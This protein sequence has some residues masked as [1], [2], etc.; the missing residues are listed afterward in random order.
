VPIQQRVDGA[1]LRLG[2]PRNELRE[3]EA[4][5]CARVDVV[6]TVASG[7]PPLSQ[8]RRRLRSSTA[9]DLRQGGL[10]GC[11]GDSPNMA[12][13]GGVNRRVE[14]DR[15][16]GV[17]HKKIRCCGGWGEG[18]RGCGVGWGGGG[19]LGW[20]RGAG[21]GGWGGNPQP[22]TLLLFCPKEILPPLLPTPP[23]LFTI[24]PG[25]VMSRHGPS[26]IRRSGLPRLKAKLM[27]GRVGVPKT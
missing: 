18:W 15:E 17:P 10:T 24:S 14:K 11:C 13:K 23:P 20:G 4:A 5:R 2:C 21:V 25:G 27:L 22:K 8:P 9:V 1:L 6:S 19:L 26:S 16:E 7:F 12:A 3:L